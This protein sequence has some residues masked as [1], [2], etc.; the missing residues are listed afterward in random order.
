[1]GG[2]NG[3]ELVLPGCNLL[4][5]LD[6]SMKNWSEQADTGG[7]TDTAG[8]WGGDRPSGRAASFHS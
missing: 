1:M 6:S 7:M 8:E 3:T 4:H 2:T 5:T